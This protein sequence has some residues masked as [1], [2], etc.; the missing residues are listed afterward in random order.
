MALNQ[1]RI[2]LTK[3]STCKKWDAAL[4]ENPSYVKRAP[5]LKNADKFDAGFFWAYAQRGG[6]DDPCSVF[7]LECAWEALERAGYNPETYEENIGVAGARTNTYLY[8]LVTNP[9]VMRSLGAFEIG[10]GNYLAFMTSR[11]SFKLNLRGPSY[12]IHTACST[13][14]AAVHLACQSLLIHECH[15]ALAGGWPSMCRKR[16]VICT[17]RAAL[18]RPMDIAGP[19]MSS[20]KARCLAAA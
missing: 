6:S 11:V 16:R 3:R 17:S 2:C 8:N 15:M 7:F 14:L 18:Y 19:L 9:E 4:L 5:L 10:L 1:L 13:A 20:H 12:S